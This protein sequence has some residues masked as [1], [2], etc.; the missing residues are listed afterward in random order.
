MPEKEIRPSPGEVWKKI[1]TD[2]RGCN[3]DEA[4]CFIYEENRKLYKAWLG[5][6]WKSDFVKEN[7]I[8]GQNGWKRVYAPPDTSALG[9]L[10]PLK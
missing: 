5:I 2:C 9:L 1:F 7:M 4:L 8:D 10:V 6:D 3:T